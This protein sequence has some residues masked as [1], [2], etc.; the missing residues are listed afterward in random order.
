MKPIEALNLANLSRY[1]AFHN[2]KMVE[3]RCLWD[4]LMLEEG[5]KSTFLFFD[6]FYFTCLLVVYFEN[7]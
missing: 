6:H 1:L 5:L 2:S 4:A 3:T 7:E